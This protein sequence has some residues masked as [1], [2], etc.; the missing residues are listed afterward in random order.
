VDVI[1][2]GTFV[3]GFERN[4]RL[5]EY[6]AAGDAV[7]RVVRADLWPED[8]IS[9][10][11]SSRL[12]TMSRMLW[13]YPALFLRLLTARRPDV[14][15]VSYPGWFDVPVVKLVALLKRRPLVFD[16]FISLYDTAVTD[17]ELASPSSLVARTARF[18]DRLAIRLSDRFIADTKTHGQFLATLA[19][20]PSRRFGVVYLGA[21]EQVF[22]PA[23]GVNVEPRS[24]VF[25]GTF[26]PLQGTEVIVQAARELGDLK[27]SLRMIGE[28]QTL[29]GTQALAEDLGLGNV[30]FPG[31]LS[32]PE[33]RDV[34]ASAAIC[35]GVFGR[36]AKA[37]R[38]V[39][40]KV[41]EA[42]AVGRPVITGRTAA[43][44]EVFESDELIAVA[45]NDPDA[46]AGA[47]RAGLDDPE[48]LESVGRA[49]HARFVRDFSVGPQSARLMDELRRVI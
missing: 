32:Q 13:V 6:L 15:L 48:K 20:V 18:V 43:I 16:V 2:A 47:I 41:Y 27:V 7:V 31:R 24:I 40:H 5:A 26:V 45:P 42:L 33:L 36:T 21:D 8:R 29:A 17:R 37:D 34:M 3:P 28:G 10:F 1:W 38:V 39:P 4:K 12:R 35:L 9:A 11:S 19:N 44:A 14:Y 25:Y 23:S 49:G 46:I 22:D 30:D